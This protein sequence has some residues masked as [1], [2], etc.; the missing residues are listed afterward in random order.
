LLLNGLVRSQLRMPN[1]GA[2]KGFNRLDTRE[3]QEW[4]K[5]DIGV[6]VFDGIEVYRRPYVRLRWT[7]S[8]RSKANELCLLPT[9]TGRSAQAQSRH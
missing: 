1:S 7:C 9:Q 5:A 4:G 3:W 6:C 2:D 8:S